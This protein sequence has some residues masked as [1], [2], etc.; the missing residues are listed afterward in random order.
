ML[1][2]EPLGNLLKR[3][4]E[5]AVAD[6]VEQPCHLDTEDFSWGD[7]EFGLLFLQVSDHQP[8]QV[9]HSD[10]VFKAVVGGAREDVVDQAALF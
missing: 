5:R 7:L 4:G 1:M 10:G 2:A 6:I 8:G 9:R 3:V